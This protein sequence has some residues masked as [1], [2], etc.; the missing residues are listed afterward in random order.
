MTNIKIDS[1]PLHIYKK[2]PL[3]IKTHKNEYELSELPFSVQQL[4]GDYIDKSIEYDSIYDCEPVISE[5][6]DF[7]V[8]D[9]IKILIKMYI[10]NYFETNVGSYPFNGSIGNELQNLLDTK[11]TNLQHLY[12]TEAMDDMIN[13]FNTSYQDYTITLNDLR[14]GKKTIESR[15]ESNISMTLNIGGSLQ[16]I[17][18]TV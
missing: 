5:F 11:D 13:V 6:G 10:K 3:S 1:L 4:V 15:V 18:V 14:I 16:N 9:D 12:L 7:K 2:I 17:D 8:I